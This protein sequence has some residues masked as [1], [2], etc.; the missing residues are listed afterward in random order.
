MVGF[1]EPEG[2]FVS[3]G[4]VPVPKGLEGYSPTGFA[5]FAENMEY[6]RTSQGSFSAAC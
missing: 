4:L 5:E 2:H 3:I 1:P 6:V